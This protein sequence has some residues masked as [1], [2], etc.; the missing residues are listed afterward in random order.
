MRLVVF[1]KETNRHRSLVIFPNS[2][3]KTVSHRIPDQTKLSIEKGL[4]PE[5]TVCHLLRYLCSGPEPSAPETTDF[6]SEWKIA[7]I[8]AAPWSRSIF[9]Q[10]VFRRFNCYKLSQNACINTSIMLRASWQCRWKLYMFLFH[11]GILHST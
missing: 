3:H 1:T 10:F 5:T 8:Q 4:V 2:W 7:V 9:M 11:L 6:L